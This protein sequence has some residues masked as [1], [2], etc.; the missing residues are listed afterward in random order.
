[1]PATDT[2]IHNRKTGKIA[3]IRTETCNGALRYSVVFGHL[4]RSGEFQVRPYRSSQSFKSETG[5][6]RAARSWIATE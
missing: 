6:L 1:M 4:L 2:C 5:A 3:D